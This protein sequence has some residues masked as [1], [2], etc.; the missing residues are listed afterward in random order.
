MKIKMGKTGILDTLQDEGRFGFSKWGINTNGAMDRFAMAAANALVGNNPNTAVMEIHFPGPELVFPSA[1]LISLA[2]ADF[3]AVISDQNI[4]VWKTIQVSSGSVLRFSRK[5]KGM[6]SYLAIH[7]G[8]EVT[9][10]LG[11]IS[12]NI[13]S[14]TG[15]WEGR[16]LKK[17]DELP[18]GVG[19]MSTRINNEL[20]IFPWSVNASPV[21]DESGPVD[22]AFGNEWSWLDHAS[23][24]S[25][26]KHQ[27]S[28]LP[29]SDRMATFLA[30]DTLHLKHTRQLLSSAVTVGT[31]Q[32]LPSGKLCVLMS[33]HQTTG[34]YPRVGHII[35]AHLPR[36]AQLSPGD[37]FTF[38][39]TSIKEAE[40]ML[41][42]LQS[43]VMAL[44]TSLKHKLHKHYGVD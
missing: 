21:Y 8:F 19:P 36:F 41:F 32:A 37:T 9:P 2:G 40:K 35:S 24:S 27:F 33:D 44:T 30:H 22:F 26:A 1:A 17:N 15:G 23:Q 20:V 28:I 38:Q 5:Q 6:R 7:G 12:T 29:S 11:S 3:S 4:P 39:H 25:F 10:W 31:I 18:I 43:S 42:S 14:H 13:K 16:S 34:G